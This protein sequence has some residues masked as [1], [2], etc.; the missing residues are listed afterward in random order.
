MRRSESL[1]T[2][3]R[4][5][6]DEECDA[7]R[8]LLQAGLARRLGSGRY[9]V[10]PAG[11]RIRSALIDRLHEA[12]RAVGGQAVSLPQLQGKDTWTQSG[13]WQSFE[14]EM[15]TLRDRDGRSLCLA[16]SHEE[17]MVEL[18]RG[19]IRSHADLPQF[20]FQTGRK[21]RDDHAR[22]GLLRTKEF[23]MTDGYSFHFDRDS[24]RS[25]YEAVREAFDQFFTDI[26]LDVVTI[27]A[28]N[29]VM[30]GSTSE[31]FIAPVD[32]GTVSLLMCE[33][34]DCSTAL[35]EESP[36]WDQITAGDSCPTC[37]GNLCRRE[38]V[39]VGHIFALETR[40][41]EAMDLTVDGPDGEYHAVLM[42]SYGVGIE[43]TLQTIVAQ[44]GDGKGCRFPV[45]AAG[46]VAPY[47]VSILPLRYEGDY[48]ESADRLYDALGP[49]DTLLFDEPSED[50][51]ERFAVSDRLGIP[52]KVILG[53]R[54]RETGQIEIESRDGETEFVDP[55]AVPEVIGD[56]LPRRSSE[57]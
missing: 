47:R 6:P 31:E 43:R 8:R 32:R 3:R 5:A 27:E 29:S 9:A 40:Y 15:F 19:F 23:T 51:G 41:S 57:S 33:T 18:V 16:P 50:M 34:A 42:G 44:H 26:G 35:T 36:R 22:N 56:R 7:A 20:L 4:D 39:E 12:L 2:Q 11:E 25:Q 14:G 49:E 38:G 24:L 13:R 46:T 53:N 52:L 37:G 30:G 10:T 48:R 21:H 28:P 55:E 54:F 1:A 17:A 45:T